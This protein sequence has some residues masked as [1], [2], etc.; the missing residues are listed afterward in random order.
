MSA[1]NGVFRIQEFRREHELMKSQLDPT[2]GTGSLLGRIGRRI[3]T[4]IISLPIG[5][6]R[7]PR[8]FSSE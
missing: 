2:S 6:R 3:N 7:T 8:T 4:L 1:D 5:H